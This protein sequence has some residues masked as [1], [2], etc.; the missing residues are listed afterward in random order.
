MGG[1]ALERG[2]HCRH[3]RLYL[4]M[5]PPRYLCV[6]AASQ[7]GSG[8]MTTPNQV[9]TLAKQLPC[10]YETLT[11][12]NRRCLE[13]QT[14]CH[15]WQY[16]IEL[17]RPVWSASCR[18]QKSIK[19]P[20]HTEP[21]ASEKHEKDSPKMEC[22]QVAKTPLKSRRMP[23]SQANATSGHLTSWI[24]LAGA[25]PRQDASIWWSCWGPS[26]SKTLALRTPR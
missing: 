11:V 19:L 24:E 16:A 7:C 25:T 13:G 21:R 15:V 1:R 2:G 3:S 4:G 18:S 22:A 26:Q 20:T 8:G 17:G 23:W 14:S 10:W 6:R 9:S 5:C 12:E